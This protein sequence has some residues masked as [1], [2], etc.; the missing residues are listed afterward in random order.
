MDSIFPFLDP[1]VAEPS[2]VAALP[3]AREV[4]WDFDLDQ[5]VTRGG[6]P[7]FVERAEA[8]AVWTWNA[9]HTE[10]WRWALYTGV[11]GNEIDSLIGQPYTLQV[12]QAEIPRLLRECLMVSPY[13]QDLQDIRSSF[14]GSKLTISF[15]LISIYG[16]VNAMEVKYHV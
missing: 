13:V 4:K 10:R 2:P 1:Q 15:T 14:A 5:P 16:R 3:V 7:V 11:Y 9:L 8:V 6:E 12:K